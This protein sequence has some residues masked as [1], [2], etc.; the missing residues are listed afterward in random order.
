MWFE[1]VT[2]QWLDKSVNAVLDRP[3][4]K[5]RVERGKRLIQIADQAR[6]IARSA[7]DDSIARDRLTEILPDDRELV[8]GA[9]ELLAR[10]RTSYVEDRAYRLLCA[11]SDGR[12]VSPID[13]DVR[14]RFLTEAELGRLSL[15]DAFQRLATLEPRLREKDLRRIVHPPSGRSGWGI[16]KAEILVGRW[17]RTADPILSTD[18][19]EDVVSEYR[20]VMG[21]APSADGQHSTPFF[22]RDHTL[23]C[24]FPRFLF[25]EDPRPRATN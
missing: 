25:A 24:G 23:T 19:A 6:E 10:G 11:S 3:E 18:L 21:E 20:A 15:T 13:P 5:T 16:S 17:A 12:Q 4:F 7:A 14:E 9:I 8:G 1:N 2:G 22:D